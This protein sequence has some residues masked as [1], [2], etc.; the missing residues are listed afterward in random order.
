MEFD[1]REAVLT[2]PGQTKLE[3]VHPRSFPS[4]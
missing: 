2:D 4:L 3:N 1:F